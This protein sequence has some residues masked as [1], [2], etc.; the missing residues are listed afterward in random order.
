DHLF[1]RPPGDLTERLVDV[2]QHGIARDD[3]RKRGLCEHLAEPVRLRTRRADLSPLFDGGRN[4]EHD[5]KHEHDVASKIPNGLTAMN[6]MPDAA[7]GP[8]DPA[9]RRRIVRAL[10]GPDGPAHTVA[11]V[12]VDVRE[13]RV[14]RR[15]RLG[16][17]PEDLA[18]G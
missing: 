8:Y 10:G 7:V 6:K 13:E 16:A 4:V 1:P 11:I 2:E 15:M 17:A 14:E 18:Q 5:A 9:D 3:E 12:R